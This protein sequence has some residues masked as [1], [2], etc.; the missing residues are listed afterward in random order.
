MEKPDTVW[1]EKPKPA[2]SLVQAGVVR[3]A[4]WAL[5]DSGD[6]KQTFF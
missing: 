3:A 2:A 6:N 5:A 1:V 4:S